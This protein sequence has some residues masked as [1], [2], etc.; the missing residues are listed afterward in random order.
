[1]KIL[2]LFTKSLLAIFALTFLVTQSASAATRYVSPNGNDTTGDG[3][4]AKPWKTFAWA[5]KATAPANPNRVVA[6]DTLYLE[7]GATFTESLYPA[8]GTVSSP[9]TITSD[10]ANPAVIRATTWAGI[11]MYDTKYVRISNIKVVGLGR[12]VTPSWLTAGIIISTKTANGCEDIVLTNVSVSESLNGVKLESPGLSPGSI[13]NITLNRCEFF[14]N[15]NTGLWAKKD[16]NF[17]S[18]TYTQSGT[19]VTVTATAHGLSV[20]DSIAIDITSG[21]GVDGT[22]TVASVS[23]NNTFTYTAG[24]SLTTSGNISLSNYSNFLTNLTVND[25]SF[26]NNYNNNTGAGA[27][28]YFDY[29]VVSSTFN[30][31]KAY[32]NGSNFGSKGQGGFYIFGGGSLT[33]KNCESFNNSGNIYNAAYKDGAGFAL[34][35]TYLTTIENCYAHDNLGAGYAIIGAGS[36]ADTTG[37]PQSGN[38]VRYSISYND[39]KGGQQGAIHLFSPSPTRYLSDSHFY[40]NTV[41]TTNSSPVWLNFGTLAGIAFRNNVFVTSPG[42][43]LVRFSTSTTTPAVSQC[44][45][46]GNNYWTGGA[47]NVA[48]FTSL[49]AWRS[50]QSQETLNGAPVGMNVNPVLNDTRPLAAV[51]SVNSMRDVSGLTAYKLHPTSPLINSGLS[52][53]YFGYS[54]TNLTDFYGST[55]PQ[56]GSYD[57]GAHERPAIATVPPSAPIGPLSITQASAGSP[58]VLTW[59]DAS[60]DETGFRVER[61]TDNTNFAVIATLAS[62]T[63]SYSDVSTSPKVLYYY[64]VHAYNS[65]GKSAAISNS[66]TVA[67]VAA[68]FLSAVSSSRGSVTLTW[69]L[70]S[71]VTSYTI[72]RA[73]SPL[74]PYTTIATGVKGTSFTNTMLKSGVKVYYIVSGIKPP[75]EVVS[76]N[77]AVVTTR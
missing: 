45:F 52:L 44:L 32:G 41:F 46:Q 47:I 62:N 2:R 66:F 26:Y 53:T 25:S 20:G 11:G 59:T 39:A 16:I 50:A 34:D 57:I 49:D 74:G 7:A 33:F 73:T 3:T 18:G 6:G 65:A 67:S 51:Y 55:L 4:Q 37:N 71:G 77:P 63:T 54:I 61:S 40:N 76:S 69:T 10:P 14:N 12:T 31:C 60:S 28:V 24:T 35:S 70:Q 68:D 58:V 56:S 5:F 42:I 36:S 19:T 23:G 29:G 21:T 8:S 9:I 38:V 30:Y 43:S 22:Y 72:R 15:S 27:G 75:G 1:M 13:R 17:L 64:R 48:G